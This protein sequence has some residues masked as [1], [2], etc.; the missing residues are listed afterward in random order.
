[1]TFDEAKDYFSDH[2]ISLLHIDGLH[3]YEAVKHDFENWK[4][5]LTPNAIV[6]FH[7]T[8]VRE[9]DFGVWKFWEE[10]AEIYPHFE[11]LHG[12]GLGILCL[13]RADQVG[14]ADLFDPTNLEDIRA[15]PTTSGGKSCFLRTTLNSIKHKSLPRIP[16]EPEFLLA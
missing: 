12:N 4:Q 11:F 7:D 9:R 14:L 8:N 15:L 16:Q 1:M 10:L 13:G 5:K 6:I 2:S 3:T